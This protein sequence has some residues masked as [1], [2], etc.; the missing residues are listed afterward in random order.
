MAKMGAAT[1]PKW[2][3]KKNVK[4]WASISA[5]GAGAASGTIGTAE[6]SGIVFS[7]PVNIAI[8]LCSGCQGAGTILGPNGA[9]GI[10][11]LR[12]FSE[13][14]GLTFAV[15]LRNRRA[16]HGTRFEVARTQLHDYV[17]AFPDGARWG[18]RDGNPRGSRVAMGHYTYFGSYWRSFTRFKGPD[19]Y[20]LFRFLGGGMPNPI[21]GW[22]QLD[23]ELS[24][25][26]VEVF[27]EDYAYNLS[28]AQIRA[29]DTGPQ[30]GPGGSSPTPEPSTFALTGLAAL[31][32]GAR[33]VRAWR[34]ARKRAN[35]HVA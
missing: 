28:G 10:L 19:E 33:G 24:R 16:P 1:A 30:E 6:A 20:V 29:G 35:P 5:L 17:A 32:L 23:V 15:S 25:G 4:R 21:Y 8:G 11:S 27:L 13:L 12:K 22:A 7:G 14:S 26:N 34:G 2:T 9:G 18:K 3:L 31:A